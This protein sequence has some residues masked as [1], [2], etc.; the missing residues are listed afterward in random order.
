MPASDIYS[1]AKILLEMLTGQR[2]STLL[3]DAALDLPER[4][5]E[6]VGGLPVQFSEESIG[7]LGA[8]LEFDP[9]RRPQDAQSF[10]QPIVRDLLLS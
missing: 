8:A 9:L 7:L 10:A 4:V 3:P 5:R 1:L 2:L 6:L